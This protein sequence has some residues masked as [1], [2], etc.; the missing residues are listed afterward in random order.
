MARAQGEQLTTYFFE[1]RCIQQDF[2]VPWVSSYTQTV[3]GRSI[4]TRHKS[5]VHFSIDVV[6]PHELTSSRL[7]RCNV[8]YALTMAP[9]SDTT[10]ATAIYR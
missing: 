8:I 10:K 2:N 7:A 6:P 1:T 4:S 9:R 5:A 3:H